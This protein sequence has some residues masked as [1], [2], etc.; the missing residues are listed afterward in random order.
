MQQPQ[1]ERVEDLDDLITRQLAG[2]REG[3]YTIQA[4][5]DQYRNAHRRFHDSLNEEFKLA[6]SESKFTTPIM[7]RL[8][9]FRRNMALVIE[10]LNEPDP[11]IGLGRCT[12]IED[13]D[14]FVEFQAFHQTGNTPTMTCTEAAHGHIKEAIVNR[15][16]QNGRFLVIRACRHHYEIISK[17]PMLF[18]KCTAQTLTEV[19]HNSVPLEP[20]GLF[21]HHVKTYYLLLQNGL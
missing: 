14:R 10:S 20:D 6:T 21:S 12:L 3:V 8:E 9:I 11:D 2:R 16:P 7:D 19:D 5:I 17:I 1:P 15:F 13:D 18:I 4:N